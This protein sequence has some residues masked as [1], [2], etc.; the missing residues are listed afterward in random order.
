MRERKEEQD[1]SYVVRS[2]ANDEWQ[3]LGIVHAENREQA[4]AKATSVWDG[5]VT[6][7][8]DVRDA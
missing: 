7:I 4:W 5:K 3:F 8:T 1:N 2:F 6:H